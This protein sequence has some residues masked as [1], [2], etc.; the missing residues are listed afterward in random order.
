MTFLQRRHEF[1]QFN[2]NLDGTLSQEPGRTG[3]RRATIV[4]QIRRSA[5]VP[6]VPKTTTWAGKAA[7]M[8]PSTLQSSGTAQAG[9]SSAAPPSAPV[10]PAADLPVPVPANRA[11]LWKYISPIIKR[12]RDTAMPQKGYVHLFLG[13]PRV[14]DIAWSGRRKYFDT[15]SRD[16]A[17]LLVQVTGDYAAEPCTN[18][19]KD[20]G[21]FAGCVVVSSKA[22]ADM[23][24][25]FEGCASCTYRY[26]EAGCSLHQTFRSRFA[27]LFPGLDYDAVR[28]RMVSGRTNLEAHADGTVNRPGA[29]ASNSKDSTARPNLPYADMHRRS[30][31]TAS[32]EV[33]AGTATPDA[34]AVERISTPTAASTAVDMVPVGNRAHA[35]AATATAAAAAAAAASPLV[36]AGD[37]RGLPPATV[38]PGVLEMEDWEVAP[39]R[40]QSRGEVG[41]DN[42]AFSN[43][44]LTSN[45]MVPITH[46]VSYRVE[47]VRSGATVAFAADAQATRLCT[48]AAGKLRVAVGETRFVIGPNGVFCARP[49]MAFSV[50]N[51]LYVDAYLHISALRG[52][53]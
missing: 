49:G 41:G 13:L 22:S 11:A 19:R 8:S 32:K 28:R 48:L 2:D 26:G 20:K 16:V 23:H 7:A 35:S 3:Q 17:S 25:V 21:P 50:E 15:Q 42:V 29:S 39:G 14:R 30:G 40:V 18:C 12:H 6:G 51:R 24:A 47:V 4:S 53:E 33:V 45:Q 9:S 37:A 44:Y 43:A 52:E 31:R 36:F 46:N 1:S 5:V 38:G 34:T 27:Q 10:P